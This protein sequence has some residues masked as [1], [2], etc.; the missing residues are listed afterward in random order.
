RGIQNAIRRGISENSTGRNAHSRPSRVADP[1]SGHAECRRRRRA[2]NKDSQVRAI[3]VRPPDV[4]HVLIG[5]YWVAEVHGAQ[6]RWNAA[7]APEGAHSPHR[8]KTRRLHLLLHDLW[9]DDVELA[10]ELV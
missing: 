2:R 3:S 10:G 1:C 8:S 5:N 6:R 7:P 9:L 4:H